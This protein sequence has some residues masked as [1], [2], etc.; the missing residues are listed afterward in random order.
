[1]EELFDWIGVTRKM[2]PPRGEIYFVAAERVLPRVAQEYAM[3]LGMQADTIG[4]SVDVTLEFPVGD[5][6]VIEYDDWAQWAYRQFERARGR[7]LSREEIYQ[8]CGL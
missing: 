4:S 6:I 8:L 7:L 2:L 3:S 5:R 1:M